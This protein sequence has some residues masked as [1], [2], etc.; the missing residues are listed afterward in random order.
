[1]ADKLIQIRSLDNFDVPFNI[2]HNSNIVQ[3]K[4]Y[5]KFLKGVADDL[6]KDVIPF[7]KPWFRNKCGIIYITANDNIVGYIAYGNEGLD[8]LYVVNLFVDSD[9]VQKDVYKMLLTAFEDIA[10][11]R[12]CISI[13]ATISVDNLTALEAA[14]DIGLIVLYKQLY[15]KI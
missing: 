3:S 6:D 7:G 13:S 11:E 14:Q 5:S 4:A 1:M 8:V 2:Y 15:K 9:Y 12:R 10:K